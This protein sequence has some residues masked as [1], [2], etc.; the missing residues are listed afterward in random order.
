[1]QQH[2]QKPVICPECSG[3]MVKRSLKHKRLLLPQ[4]KAMLTQL[5]GT[6]CPGYNKGPVLASWF[7]PG[8][9]CTMKKLSLP[10][11]PLRESVVCHLRVSHKSAALMN[12]SPGDE[13]VNAGPTP[14]G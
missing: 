5:G 7:L 8:T 11:L 1:M 2:F 13:L 4:A 10:A 12:Q 14:R 6:Q 3:F 9:R